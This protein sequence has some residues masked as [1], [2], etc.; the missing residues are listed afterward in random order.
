[1]RNVEETVKA[2]EGIWKKAL[3]KGLYTPLVIARAK[4]KKAGV[5]DGLYLREGLEGALVGL[6]GMVDECDLTDAEKTAAAKELAGRYVVEKKGG[7][8]MCRI[9]DAL[10]PPLVELPGYGIV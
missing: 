7:Y 6:C 3:E 4:H 10:E 9:P 8:E 5:N 2:M 1:M